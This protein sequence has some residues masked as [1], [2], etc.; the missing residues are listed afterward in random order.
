[1]EQAWLTKL[2]A[3]QPASTATDAQLRETFATLKAE[4]AV[5]PTTTYEQVQSQIQPYAKT[6]GPAYAL[7]DGLVATEKK[8]D[9]TINPLYATSCSTPP[10][11]TFG[12]TIDYMR[13]PS[14]GQ[15]QTDQSGNAIPAV[16]LPMG[17]NSDP[18]VLDLPTPVATS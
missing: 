2:L 18:A 5:D 15:V 6:L 8:S 17:T 4:G 16:L 9:L 1:M 12:V 10:C 7:R 3:A 13:D 11:A 14:T